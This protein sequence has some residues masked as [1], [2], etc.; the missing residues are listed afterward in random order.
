MI[1]CI[2][3]CL[4]Q[5]WAQSLGKESE[6]LD[7]AIYVA[8]VVDDWADLDE[9]DESRML[10][11]FKVNTIGPLLT[12]QA[13]IRQQLLAKGSVLAIL[14]SKVTLCSVCAEHGN[15]LHPDAALH[16]LG[17]CI[18]SQNLLNLLLCGSSYCTVSHI[19][20]VRYI[21]NAKP[22]GSE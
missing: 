14:T 18:F 22:A 6:P 13:L 12:A 21:C 15:E 2:I 9:V 17:T 19:A 11:C 5:E 8:G 4:G 16:R 20:D 3:R 10:H 1:S 7:Y